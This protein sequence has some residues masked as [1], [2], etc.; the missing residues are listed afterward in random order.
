MST[1]AV[2]FEPLTGFTPPSTLGPY[3]AAD[4]W[5]L[6]EGEPVEL[7]R[8]RLI[9][10]PAPDT[11]HQTVLILLGS[12]VLGIA[13][14]S[15]GRALVAPTDVVLDD[16]TIVQPDVLYVRR[17]RRSIVQKRVIGAPDLLVEILSPHN[18]RR[19]RIDKLNLY[20]Q[21]GVAEYWIVDPQ[22][23]QFE[24]LVNRNGKFEIQPQQDDRYMSPVCPELE[25]NLAEF[26]RSID[27]QLDP[28][29]A[30]REP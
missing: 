15:R 19:D 28:G 11:L 8:G 30:P 23:R 2:Q 5:K 7:L 13:R 27:E 10:S 3:R 6:P 24:F 21:Y 17:E 25:I 29:P 4:Y 14:Q 22:E 16:H 1:D 18:S 12:Q 26:W 9:V 20:A